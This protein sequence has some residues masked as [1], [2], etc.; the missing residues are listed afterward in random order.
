MEDTI[1]NLAPDSL[2]ITCMIWNVQG[3][4]SKHF[5][6]NLKDLVKINKP[7]VLALVETHMGG[8]QAV[9]IGSILGYDGHVRTDAIGFSGGIWIYWKTE[10]VTISP[11]I[12]HNQHI[13][14]E[15]TRIGEIPWYFTAV[16][17]S[18]DPSKRRELWSELEQF[19]QSHG[20][21]WL[22]AGDFNETRFLSERNSS[23]NETNRRSAM[24]NDWIEGMD[25]LEVEFSGA[26]HTWARGKTP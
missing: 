5:I 19:A 18:P 11:I 10:V 25:L 14:M 13:S 12:K 21:P 20:K 24:F 6:S 2:P 8:E 1:P 15:I 9:K 26:A 16:Y 3:A 17:A 23:C 4:G 7:N 22:L